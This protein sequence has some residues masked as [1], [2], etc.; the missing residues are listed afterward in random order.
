MITIPNAYVPIQND[1]GRISNNEREFIIN[2]A[3]LSITDESNYD[4][5]LKNNNNNNKMG[6]ITTRQSPG[7]NRIDGRS[8]QQIRPI[9]LHF[10][11]GDNMAT[12]TIKWGA[13]TRITCSV[14]GQLIIPSNERP[15]EG[16]IS[17]SVDIS[18]SANTS[19]RHTI[20]LSN[21]NNSH[22]SDDV[23]SSASNSMTMLPNAE[24]HQKLLSN[25]I[26]RCLERLIIQGGVLDPEALCVTVA[27]HVWRLSIAVTVMDAGGNVLDASVMACMAALR[28]YRKPVVQMMNQTTDEQNDE[29]YE[30]VKQQQ[31]SINSKTSKGTST[32]M[33]IP[34]ILS[35]NIKEPTPLPLHHTPL[36]ITFGLIS[37]SDATI[38]TKN[39]SSSTMPWIVPL[40][41]PNS[42]EELCCK[43]Y[44]TIGLNVHQEICLFEF[45]GGCEMPPHQFR[46]LYQISLLQI[47]SLFAS[48][49]QSLEMANEQAIQHRLRLLQISTSSKSLPPEITTTA[50]L[51]PPELS[52]SSAGVP[53]YQLRNQGD[54]GT[55]AT[56]SSAMD[57][58][59]IQHVLEEEYKRQALD[60]N[61]GHIA[62]KVKEDT[63]KAAKGNAN[64]T[65][66]NPSSSLLLTAL[67][68]SVAGN[69]ATASLQQ[70]EQQQMSPFEHIEPV[71]GNQKEIKVDDNANQSKSQEERTNKQEQTQLQQ[72]RKMAV[73][74]YHDDDD[75]EE[76]DV[77]M[78]LV[79]EFDG[80]KQ[81]QPIPGSSIPV[82]D[83]KQG[84]NT[85]KIATTKK[86]HDTHHHSDN[87]PLDGDD[88]PDDLAAAIKTTNKKK[89]K[90]KK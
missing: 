60:Y 67:L 5:S 50:A 14:L 42:R 65:K 58:Q 63:P 52:L 43:G 30:K 6:A 18:S 15:N 75:E 57:D 10:T 7:V 24:K 20:P 33:S 86:E 23:T 36:S 82:V 31:R 46:H 4:P 47:P 62:T 73:V 88:E 16:I 17:I 51:Q 38:T 34:M 37:S 29:E 11:R 79:S 61:I 32:T 80:I 72:Q 78:Q 2:Q 55:G 35:P 45:T 9:Q 44:F 26:L 71:D 54:I 66:L 28:H 74:Q 64:T 77:T 12:C 3:C 21:Y 39:L 87:K 13:S 68:Q 70:G 25:R 19:F 49:E 83:V 81:P 76:E 56:E 90:S 40:M 27:K 53:F 69:S 89:K 84:N 48:F 41:D 8:L 1:S 59:N 85:D 22:R